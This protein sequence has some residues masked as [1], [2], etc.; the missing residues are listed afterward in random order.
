MKDNFS[1]L[2]L[3]PEEKLVLGLLFFTIIL[4]QCRIHGMFGAGILVSAPK[5]GAQK[6]RA[7]PYPTVSFFI[8]QIK[9]F[10]LC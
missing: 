4:T 10:L 3:Q 1:D 8:K 2:T 9:S 7:V 6:N 5:K